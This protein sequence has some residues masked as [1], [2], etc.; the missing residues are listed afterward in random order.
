MLLKVKGILLCNYTECYRILFYNACGGLKN[1][2][3]HVTLSFKNLVSGP[4]T[5][6]QIPEL[7]IQLRC[8]SRD[9]SRSDTEPG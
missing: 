9:I 2:A 6:A 1:Y 4:N 7:G 3:K 5:G 8:T